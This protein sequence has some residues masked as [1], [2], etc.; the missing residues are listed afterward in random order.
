M[1]RIGLPARAGLVQAYPNP[2]LAGAPL[3]VVANSATPVVIS[4]YDMLGR[5][6][7]KATAEGLINMIDTGGLKPG[8][9]LLHVQ[10]DNNPG[11]TLK[12][13]IQ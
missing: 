2:V 4:L 13:V 6:Q 8:L 1:R 5:F 3:T 11:Q 10:Q 7:R 12:I 9:Y